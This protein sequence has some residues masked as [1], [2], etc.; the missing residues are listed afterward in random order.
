MKTSASYDDMLKGNSRF[1]QYVFPRKRE[2]FTELA[3]G[4]T[5]HVMLLTCSDSRIDPCEITQSEPGDLFVI[6]NEGNIAPVFSGSSSG[7]IASIEFGVCALK[8][9]HIVVCG[10]SDCGAMKGL[11]EPEGC[12]HLGYVSAWIHEAEPALS[13]LDASD[14]TPEERLIRVTEANVLQQLESLRHLDFV[15]EAER[16]GELELHGWVYDIGSGEI[17]VLSERSQSKMNVSSV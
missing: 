17:T 8:T 9:K 15:K 12:A 13:V 6:R 2:M 10:H 1:K 7:E 11:L 14:L 3:K 4:Q 16:A 5:P